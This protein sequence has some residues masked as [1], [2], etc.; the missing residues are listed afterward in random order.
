MPIEDCCDNAD[1]TST[2]WRRVAPVLRS[3]CR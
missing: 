2:N 1:S 3:A